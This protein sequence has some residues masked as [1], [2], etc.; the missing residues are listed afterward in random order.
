MHINPKKFSFLLLP[1]FTLLS[2]VSAIEVLRQVNKVMGADTVEWQALSL[3]GNPVRSSNGMLMPVDGMISETNYVPWL[4]VCSEDLVPETKSSKLYSYLNMLDRFGAI[5]GGCGS[6]TYILA[7]SGL[8]RDKS[9]TIHWEYL[10]SMQEE[11]PELDLTLDLHIIH[12]RRFTC[13]GGAAVL[14]LM[15]TYCEKY[16]GTEVS[17]EIRCQLLIN[18]S[19]EDR[20]YYQRSTLVS[21]SARYHPTLVKAIQLIE[22]NM[23]AP[24]TRKELADECGASIRNI[25]RLFQR[26][27]KM[28]PAAYYVD[29]RLKRSRNL[30][31]NTAMPISE[32]ALACGFRS[33]S[34]FSKR[35][36]DKFGL[37]P[38]SL[39]SNKSSQSDV[40][41]ARS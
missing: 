13:S 34:H 4:C 24:L 23:E 31:L 21:R 16:F 1:D 18:Q 14:D 5:V 32:I 33:A 36:R 20:Q 22:D 15:M 30:L 38:L 29:V 41:Q 9:S 7:R 39:R 2:Y 8:L 17:D 26:A 28:G 6:A 19:L 40:K 12:D 11:F 3:D 25:E 10:N 35:F 27:F 37:T